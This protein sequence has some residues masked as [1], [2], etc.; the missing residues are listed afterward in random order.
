MMR[1]LSFVQASREWLWENEV[2]H[3]GRGWNSRMVRN[4]QFSPGKTVSVCLLTDRNYVPG[5]H[6]IAVILEFLS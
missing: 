3:L 2:F 4:Y 6:V 1:S 5:I